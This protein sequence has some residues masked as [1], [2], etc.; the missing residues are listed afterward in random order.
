MVV[1][2]SHHFVTFLA[3]LGLLVSYSLSFPLP[4][5]FFHFLYV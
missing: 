1:C 4:T 2:V 5:P 3:F